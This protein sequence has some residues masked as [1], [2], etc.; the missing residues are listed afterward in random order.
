MRTPSSFA[1]ELLVNLLLDAGVAPNDLGQ[2]LDALGQKAF[3]FNIDLSGPPRSAWFGAINAL[4]AA[5]MLAET[6]VDALGLHDQLTQRTEDLDRVRC[7]MELRSSETAVLSPADLAEAKAAA[8]AGGLHDGL[9]FAVLGAKK[10]TE[11]GRRAGTTLDKTDQLNA[12]FDAANRQDVG[13]FD[14]VWMD[15][16]LTAAVAA[17]APTGKERLQQVLDRLRLRIFREPPPVAKVDGLEQIVKT[18]GITVSAGDFVERM[19]TSMARICLVR[20]GGQDLG[21]GFL[22]GPDLVLTNHHVL[23]SVIGGQKMA[24]DVTFVFD[25]RTMGGAVH[26]GPSVGLLIA[27]ADAANPR[28]W[29]VD[30]T[31]ATDEERRP[32][33]ANPDIT[34]PTDTDHLDFAL[35]RLAEPMGTKPGHDG[36][37]RGHFVLKPSGPT[38][39]FPAESALIIVG[40]PARPNTSPQRCAPQVLA[41]EPDSVMALNPNATR[42]R[43]RTNT[44]RGSSGSPVLS[45]QWELV[46]LHHFGRTGR[47]NQGVPA[48]AIAARPAVAA[49]LP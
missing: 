7:A 34:Q 44:L 19:A 31:P 6:F 18:F 13:E 22:V 46:A 10:P 8:R 47:Y 2:I 1:R 12:W 39:T 23:E 27:G 32:I 38:F 4:S 36:A 20:L 48:A 28:P 21:T 11:V 17:A 43:Y 35:V 16:L 9:G 42:V 14:A 26:E 49:A 15:G 40:H 3:V 29:L 25:F 30:S 41:I 45:A 5:G 24:D 37:A 33:A